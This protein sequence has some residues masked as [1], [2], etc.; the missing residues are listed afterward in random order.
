MTA[1]MLYGQ[2]DPIAWATEDHRCAHLLA[3]EPSFDD[4]TDSESDES[5]YRS[6]G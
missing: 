4:Q 2:D 1:R 3:R 6:Y 5:L